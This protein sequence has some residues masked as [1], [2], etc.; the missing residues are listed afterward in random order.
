LD[1]QSADPWCL[2][3]M[4]RGVEVLG[5]AHAADVLLHEMVHVA[6]FA[7]GVEHREDDSHHNTPEWCEQITR[8]TPQLHLEPIKAAPVKPRRVN[9]KVVRRPLDGHLARAVIARWPH[10]LRPAGYYTRDGRID[11]SI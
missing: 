3:E 1:P 5:A 6:L 8:I 10:T 7:A 9:G 11:V 4:T 2:Q